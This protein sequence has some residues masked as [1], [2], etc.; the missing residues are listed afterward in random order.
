MYVNV[1]VYMYGEDARVHASVCM[2]VCW[3]L[4]LVMCMWWYVKVSVQRG[5]TR[6]E[7]CMYVCMILC[8]NLSPIMMYMYYIMM[9][10]TNICVC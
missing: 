7:F 2:I 3:D 9:C 5:W 1:N 4:S 6:V 8:W 10:N